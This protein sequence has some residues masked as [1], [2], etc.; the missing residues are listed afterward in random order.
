MTWLALSLYALGVVGAAVAVNGSPDGRNVAP[1]LREWAVVIFWPLAV[2]AAICLG[3]FTSV[4]RA[5]R[6]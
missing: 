3:L 5:C 1:G 6:P 4:R 2:A